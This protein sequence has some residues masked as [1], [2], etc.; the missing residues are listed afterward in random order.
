MGDRVVAIAES[1]GWG[2]V[3]K[4]DIGVVKSL[5]SDGGYYVDFLYQ[6]SWHGKESCFQLAETVDETSTTSENITFSLTNT[7]L[8]TKI[9][10]PI[11]DVEN[12][13]VLITKKSKIRV[14]SI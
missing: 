4:G 2:G 6:K 5:D 11:K 13:N 3:K 7:Q 8:V 12:V 1:H 14:L 9:T 10:N